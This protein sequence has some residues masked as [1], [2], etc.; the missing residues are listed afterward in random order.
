[1]IRR[2]PRSTLFPYTTLFRSV[3]GGRLTSSL[4]NGLCALS[5]GVSP[6]WSGLAASGT[7]PPG[8]TAHAA[9]YDPVRDR[10][11]VFGGLAGSTRQNDVWALSLGSSP[12]WSELAPVGT[13][14]SG[15][16]Y[17]TAIYDP[18]RDRML[19]FAGEDDQGFRNDV[20]ELPL[21]ATLAWSQLSPS[22]TPPLAR[23]YT[24]AIYDPVRDRMVVFGGYDGSIDNDAWADRKS[25]V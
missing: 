6:S 11:L 21:N 13:P 3:F 9:I 17:A 24:S 14:P 1:M 4:T 16:L 10:M 8:R 5:L 15:R 23:A 12:A 20:W 7:A 2:P 25:V 19:V 18:V 22:G